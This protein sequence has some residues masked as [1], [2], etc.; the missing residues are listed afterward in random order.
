[1]IF[2]RCSRVVMAGLLAGSLAFAMPDYSEARHMAM[3]PE[4]ETK[5]DME[6]SQVHM[7]TK[8]DMEISLD[9]DMRLKEAH[10]IAE[11]LHDE[12]EDRYPNIKHIMIHMNPAGYGYKV[13]KM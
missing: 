8:E 1:M 13:P 7:E 12:I 10:D 11:Q 9:G 3:N 6:I 2:D 4:M 5:V